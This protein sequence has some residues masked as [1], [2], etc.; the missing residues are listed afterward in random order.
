MKIVFYWLGKLFS[1]I[2][3]YKFIEILYS[4]RS[5]FYTGMISHN[6]KFFGKSKVSGPFTKLLGSKYIFVGDDISFGYNVTLTAWD[7]HMEQTFAPIIEIGSGTVIG[8]ECHITAINKIIIGRNVLMGKKIT[9]SDNSHGKILCEELRM[10]PLKRELYSK[11][12]VIIEDGVWIGDKATVL[13][14]VTIGENCIVGAN[15]VVTKDCPANSVVGGIPSRIL[16]II[17]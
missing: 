1:F 5:V 14:G 6:F 16:K 2:V 11:G 8:D 12:P 10:P 15:A 7:N 17:S 13:A 3:P 9:I 4:I